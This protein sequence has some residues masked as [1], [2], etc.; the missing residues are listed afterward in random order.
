MVLT[1]TD[2][3]STVAEIRR[4]ED[5]GIAAAWL[6]SDGAGGDPATIFAAAA[7]STERILMGTSILPIW[8]KHP[9]ALAA[10]AQAL[11]LLSQGRFRLGVETSA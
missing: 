9:I 7:T 6:R 8:A 2:P 1:T 5:M 11:S 10:Q 4:L 3:S